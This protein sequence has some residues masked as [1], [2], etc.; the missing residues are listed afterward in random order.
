MWWCCG[1]QDKNAKGCLIASHVA[2]KNDRLQNNEDVP[3]LTKC[4]CCKQ[5]GHLSNECP[6]DPNIRGHKFFPADETDRIEDTEQTQYKKM[7]RDSLN[8]TTLKMIRIF[9]R[10]KNQS[11]KGKEIMSFDDYQYD[12]INDDVFNLNQDKSKSEKTDYDDSGSSY[13]DKGEDANSEKDVN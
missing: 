6:R 10:T 9:S 7:H 5:A 8:D 1:K 4:A 11:L 12:I 3:N 13:L 2:N